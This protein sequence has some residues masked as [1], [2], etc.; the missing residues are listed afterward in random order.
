MLSKVDGL[1]VELRVLRIAPIFDAEPLLPRRLGAVVR[2]PLTGQF[3]SAQVEAKWR[4]AKWFE[5]EINNRS[6][7]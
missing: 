2:G 6:I 4:F 1:A 5:G 7:C 3:E